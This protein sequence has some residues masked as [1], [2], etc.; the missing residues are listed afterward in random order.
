MTTPFDLLR[1]RA[2]RDPGSPF[3]T[4]YGTEGVRTE[5]SGITFATSV[6]KT[7]G[8]LAGELETSP[9]D[10]I[11]LLLPL[12][13]QLP[14]WV[15]AADLT[16]LTVLWDD[17]P[18]DVTVTSHAD[19]PPSPATV[20][21]SAAT[22]FGMPTQPVP[23]PLVD[24]F[25]AAMGQPDVYLGVP[26]TGR[27]LADGRTYSDADL[28]SATQRLVAPAG[29]GRHLLVPPRTSTREAALVAWLGPLLTG[30]SCV[31]VQAGD[32]DRIAAAE[33]AVFA[34]VDERVPAPQAEP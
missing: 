22:P 11:R 14:V 34:T 24:H 33:R 23:A 18:V 29:A 3:V 2:T 7:A 8:L 10:R 30:G 20:V 21:V 5:L 6:A 27:W 32:A 28:T 1:A 19:V 15:A 16:G 9:G 31:L 4:W 12:H 26:A 25:S 17:G 13:W